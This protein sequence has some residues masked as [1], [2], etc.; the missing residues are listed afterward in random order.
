MKALARTLRRNQTDAEQRLWLR[1]RNRQLAGY[2]FRRQLPIPPY[3]VDFVC[4]E[5]HLIIELD[6]AQ[7]QSSIAADNKRTAWLEKLGFQVIRF[8]DNDVLNSTD[9]VLEKILEYI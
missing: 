6:G 5:S 8:W 1:L 3:I 2:K 9:A 4:I 7:H